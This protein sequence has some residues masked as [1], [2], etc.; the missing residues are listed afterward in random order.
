MRLLEKLREEE[1]ELR[2]VPREAL[3]C[4]VSFYLEIGK[5][6]KSKFIIVLLHSRQ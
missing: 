5:S 2:W 4:L 3:T 1:V 6:N